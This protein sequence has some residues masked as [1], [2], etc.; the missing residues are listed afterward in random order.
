MF[1]GAR[2]EADAAIYMKGGE[3]VL[4]NSDPYLPKRRWFDRKKKAQR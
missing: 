4:P 3:T 1:A 2:T